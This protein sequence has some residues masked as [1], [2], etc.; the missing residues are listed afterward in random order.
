LFRK[1][2]SSRLFEELRGKEAAR[3][4]RRSRHTR[5]VFKVQPRFSR[6]KFEAGDGEAVFHG[7]R[8]DGTGKRTLLLPRSKGD[9]L[10]RQGASGEHFLGSKVELDDEK[11]I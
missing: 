6:R 8:L 5:K 7:I 11:R 2:L 4:R 3:K 9:T 10:K 1:T